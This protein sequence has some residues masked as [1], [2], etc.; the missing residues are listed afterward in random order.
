MKLYRKVCN[1]KLIEKYM[2]IT[3]LLMYL[4]ETAIKEEDQVIELIEPA[5]D[6]L[7]QI[8]LNALAILKEELDNG[9]FATFQNLKLINFFA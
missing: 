4:D 7:P 1:I 3:S 2:Y 8:A 6:K 5:L 9:N